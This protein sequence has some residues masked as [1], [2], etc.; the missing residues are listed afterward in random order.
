M[1][2]PMLFLALLA[3]PSGNSVEDNVHSEKWVRYA[4]VASA[5][6]FKRYICAWN[7]MT[8]V[9]YLPRPGVGVYFPEA[10]LQ[11]KRHPL[12]DI[13]PWKSE[14]CNVYVFMGDYICHA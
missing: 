7:G 3:L 9:A 5:T 8:V 1:N 2:C 11:R 12:K 13:G 14:L 4:V 6:L 10:F